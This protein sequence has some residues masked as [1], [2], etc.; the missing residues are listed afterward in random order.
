MCLLPRRG[1][2]QLTL[3]LAHFPA[4][5]PVKPPLEPPAHL[6]AEAPAHLPAEAPAHVP[7]YQPPAYLPS[8]LRSIHS[9][10]LPYSLHSSGAPS[11]PSSGS[12]SGAS[13][14]QALF[15]DSDVELRPVEMRD[16]R[17]KKT[18]SFRAEHVA[19]AF[20]SNLPISK[21][22]RPSNWALTMCFSDCLGR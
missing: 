12:P 11:P 19:A 10:N 15:I 1:R 6:P 22:A 3:P 5:C 18:I 21:G 9:C 2:L 20:G 4:Y 13:S 7:A 17:T 14:L 8:S 16:G